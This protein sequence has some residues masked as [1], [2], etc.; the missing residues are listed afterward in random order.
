[1][2]RAFFRLVF[3]LKGWK[4]DP[5]TFKL[6][7]QYQRCVLIAA[8]HTSNWDSVMAFAGLDIMGVPLR[9]TVKKELNKPILGKILEEMGALWIDRSRKGMS[10]KS[11]VDVMV[12]L[13]AQNERIALIVTP[14]GTRSAVN[15]WKSGFFH[16]AERAGVPIALGFVDYENKVAGVGKI[17]D[18]ALGYDEVMYQMM[19]FYRDIK[20]CYPE[21]FALDKKY[22]H[23]PAQTE[24]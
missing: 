15:T 6:K 13:F 19:D 20:G 23:R 17:L 8:P 10:R 22:A 2:L 5:N 4:M 24:A 1:M 11:M 14:E 12:E 16:V 18:P 9:Y 7:D 21:K 3:R